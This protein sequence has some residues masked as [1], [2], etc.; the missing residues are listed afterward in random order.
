MDPPGC[1]P[2]ALGN[3]PLTEKQLVQ[4]RYLVYFDQF[5]DQPRV[6]YPFAP[7]LPT[8]GALSPP[9]VP[10]P[11]WSRPPLFSHQ[12]KSVASLRRQ[13]FR[14]PPTPLVQLTPTQLW[15]IYRRLYHVPEPL[16]GQGP[17]A[18]FPPVTEKA[19]QRSFW[20]NPTPRMVRRSTWYRS[21]GYQGGSAEEIDGR[22]SRGDPTPPPRPRPKLKKLS[23]RQQLRHRYR[24]F[25]N[26]RNRTCPLSLVL[27]QRRSAL[28]GWV[29]RWETL[30]L[31]RLWQSFAYKPSRKWPPLSDPTAYP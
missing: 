23:L 21:R 22:L 15:A 26:W 5:S 28:T 17:L 20:G 10:N 12:P 11:E 18:G 3:S 4:L 9:L 31:F 29:T 24:R 8:H 1:L 14:K 30:L 25:Q 16:F 6:W 7:E 2:P 19:A 13:G 27:P